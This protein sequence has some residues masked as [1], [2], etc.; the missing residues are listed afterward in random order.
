MENTLEVRLLHAI[1]T[2][3]E[4]TSTNPVLLE[5]EVGYTSDKIGLFKIGDGVSNWK[6]LSYGRSNGIEG[7]IATIAELNYS[8]GLKGNI[9]KQIDALNK[10]GDYLPLSGGT[11]NN[12]ASIVIP[13]GTSGNKAEYGSNIAFWGQVGGW[14]LGIYFKDSSGNTISDGFCAY[15]VDKNLRYYYIGGTYSQPTY[16]FLPDGELVA[17]KFTGIFNTPR[18][19]G[20]STDL[21]GNPQHGSNDINGYYTL[22]S[23]NGSQGFKYFWETKNL[24]IDGEI[25]ASNFNGNANSATKLENSAKIN[26]TSFDGTANI[27]TANWGTARN[28]TIGGATKSVNGS[29]DIYWS[30]SEIGFRKEWTAR[31]EGLTWSRLC[32][33]KGGVTA[34]ASY[35]LNVSGTRNAVVY[36][37]TYIIKSHH[38]RAGKIIK[39]S[40]N[41]YSSGYKIRLLV[42]IDGDNYV[43]FYDNANGI[44]VSTSQSVHCRMIPIFTEAVTP[45][46]SF[47]S[48]ETVPSNFAVVQTMTVNKTD[49]QGNLDGNATTAT[50]SSALIDSY[51]GKNIT[52]T[53][54]KDGQSS[55]SWLASWNGYELGA[56]SPSKVSVGSADKASTATSVLDYGDTSRSIQIGY[57][58]TGLTASTISHVAGYTDNGTKI[59]DISKD[60]LKSWLGLGSAAYTAS[61]AYASSSHKQAYTSAECTEYTPDDDTMGITPAAVKKAITQVFEP[62]AH[63][64]GLLHSDFT[65]V[66]PNTT[67]DSGWSM[68]NSSYYGFILKSFRTVGNAPDWTIGNYSAGIAFGGADTKGVM[69]CAFDAAKVKFAGGNGSKP[70]WNMTIRGTSGKTYNLDSLS[71]NNTTYSLSKSGNTITLTGSDGSKTSVADTDTNTTYS[72]GTGL[73]L[74]G[75]TFSLAT[76]G[77]KAGAYGTALSDLVTPGFNGIFLVPNLT[78]DTY[79]R[80]TYGKDIAVQLPGITGSGSVSVNSDN[81]GNITISEIG[82]NYKTVTVSGDGWKRIASSSSG[83]GNCSGIFSLVAEVSGRHTTLVFEASTCYGTL[84]SSYINILGSSQYSSLGLT[85]IRI[86]YN[87][88]YSGNYAYIEVESTGTTTLKIQT[89]GTNEWNLITPVSG[90]IP[91]GYASKAYDLKTFAA[92]EIVYQHNMGITFPYGGRYSSDILTDIDFNNYLAPINSPLLVDEDTKNAYYTDWKFAIRTIKFINHSMALITIEGVRNA[93]DYA[94]VRGHIGISGGQHIDW[95]QIT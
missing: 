42:N 77:V 13:S 74:S 89:L 38:S 79:G 6:D 65:S 4:W 16:K 24:E 68:I 44:S 15:G 22:M 80:V 82:S 11:M 19:D 70:V 78:V 35:I 47:V 31:I 25:T 88:K 32:H 63:T 5:G 61:S 45:Y 92:Y 26:G 23:Y 2:E 49:M 8:S 1:K 83:I 54:G 93:D 48:G 50:A 85:G 10:F 69:T 27:T 30:P 56:I 14:A 86:V 87:S 81:S 29:G 72:A 66:I 51:D 20:Y 84:S 64:H 76:S 21:R 40:G 36:N 33:V 55:T 62:K 58:G 75:T 34:G 3:A 43:E 53:Y 18:I 52:V 90:S 9:Q 60:N 94:C 28:L 57:A 67:A 39:I 46:T 59:K 41:T 17:S 91:S 95:G 7:L 73:S 71:S 12:G 37:D